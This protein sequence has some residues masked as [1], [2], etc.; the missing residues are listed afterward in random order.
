VISLDTLSPGE[1]VALLARLVGRA[2]LGSPAD[3]AG[4]IARLCGYLPL[5][6]GMLARQLRHYPART[7]AELAADLAAARD[8]LAI[9]RAENLSVAA[10]FDLS[11]HKISPRLSSGCSVGSASSRAG[12][13][14]RTPP[15]PST[16][17]AW[18]PSAASSMS[19]TT[20]I[21]SPSRS[22]AA[23]CSTTCCA[24]TALT[25]QL[26][27]AGAGP[28]G[29]LAQQLL[30]SRGQLHRPLVPGPGWSSRQSLVSPPSR[31]LHR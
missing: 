15:R 25:G 23:T 6:I 28:L 3:P 12:T 30:I 27:P 5:A 14:T 2:D 24:N 9:M 16:T 4:Q 8:R 29:Q 21:R 31:E 13:S 18:Q 7:G 17:P 19:S 1:A 10:A 26:Q 11:Y 22:P 20:I